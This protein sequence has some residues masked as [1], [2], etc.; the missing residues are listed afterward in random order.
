MAD[1]CLHREI[2]LAHLLP[3]S[4]GQLISI[5]PQQMQLTVCQSV[6]RTKSA[7]D[8]MK[9][10]SH[11]VALSGSEE[12]MEH[13]AN[14]GLILKRSAME[15]SLVQSGSSLKSVFQV[16]RISKM[17]VLFLISPKTLGRSHCS[18][19]QFSISKECR[20]VGEETTQLVIC[21]LMY[22]LKDKEV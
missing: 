17:I 1:N 19:P 14:P 5:D 8:R 7:G 4:E 15:E 13:M 10:F 16:R 18:K 6:P 2:S 11:F 22:L 3:I 9:I 20:E 12:V 21:M